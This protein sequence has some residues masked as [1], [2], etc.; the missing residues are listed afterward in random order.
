VAKHTTILVLT[1][2]SS[3]HHAK[4]GCPTG[5]EAK[6]V[7]DKLPLVGELYFGSK[8]VIF[9]ICFMPN[10]AYRVDNIPENKSINQHKYPRGRESHAIA[11]NNAMTHILGSRRV[12]MNLLKIRQRVTPPVITLSLVPFPVL[13]FN[14]SLIDFNS[15]DS[16]DTFL[17]RQE[18]CSQRR[19]GE[20]EPHCT[21]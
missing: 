8:L 13:I 5:R 7:H 3:I 14:S 4:Q 19:I 2:Y 18:M 21:S 16:K 1:F 10:V 12:S 20:K 9:S 6:L 17:G 11:A 15:L